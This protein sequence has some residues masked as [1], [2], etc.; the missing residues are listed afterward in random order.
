[1]FKGVY[2]TRPITSASND[3]KPSLRRSLDEECV[4]RLISLDSFD[5]K[6]PQMVQYNWRIERG[7]SPYILSDGGKHNRRGC[8]TSIAETIW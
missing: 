7:E 5:L 6:A 8:E 3:K 1:M 2:T 4:K